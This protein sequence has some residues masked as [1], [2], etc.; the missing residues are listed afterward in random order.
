MPAVG[1]PQTRVATVR[2][3]FLVD[4]PFGHPAEVL[5]LFW[6]LL[7]HQMESPFGGFILIRGLVFRRVPIAEDVN[8]WGTSFLVGLVFGN[9]LHPSGNLARS[10]AKRGGLAEVV[11]RRDHLVADFRS[12]LFGKLRNFRR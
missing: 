12:R 11:F 2:T 6:F 5:V 7:F 10:F 3:G 9:G 1:L 4:F 8:I